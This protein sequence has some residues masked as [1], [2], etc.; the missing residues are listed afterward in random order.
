MFTSKEKRAAVIAAIETEFGFPY[1]KARRIVRHLKRCETQLNFYY[2]KEN[3]E[4]FYN[5]YFTK[6]GEDGMMHCEALDKLEENVSKYI[7]RELGCNFYLND[8]P[9]A[10]HVRLYL[11]NFRNS[12][13]GETTCIN[14]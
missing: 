10:C 9:R 5:K 8:D 12:Y 2:E 4:R 13:D 14:W 6:L 1:E 11:K 3:D 7:T